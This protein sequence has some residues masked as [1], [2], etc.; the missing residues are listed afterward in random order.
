MTPK[1]EIRLTSKL[2]PEYSSNITIDNVTYHVQTE[3]MGIKSGKVI[4]NIFLKG[5][6]VFNRKSEY[7]HLIK[8]KN[9]PEKLSSLMENL[10]KATIDHFIAEKTNRQKYKSQYFEEV[11]QLLRRGNGKSALHTLRQALDTFPADPFLLSY[12]GCLLAIVEKKPKE[13]IKICEDAI[14]KLD[15]SMPFGAE[16]FYPAFYL[17]LGRAY[18]KGNRKT[19]ALKAFQKGLQN[20]PESHDILWEMKKMGTRK[21]PV[22]PFLSR[23]NPINKYIGML[24]HPTV[25]K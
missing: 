13:G 4:S 23:S 8:L 6:V 18:L 10:H 14:K 7:S 9:F 11:Q 12:Y 2:S 5:E 17:N 25:K 20:D 1:S 22:L 16:F 21:K 24:I 15:N 3:D 19:E